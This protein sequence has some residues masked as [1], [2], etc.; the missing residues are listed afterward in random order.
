MHSTPNV[1]LYAPGFNEL[2]SS[3][4][5]DNVAQRLARTLDH[6]DQDAPISYE[7]RVA[8]SE[9]YAG[10]TA[11]AEVRELV[12]CQ[13]GQEPVLTHRL[14][15]LDYQPAL[16]DQQPEGNLFT[17]MLAVARVSAWMGWCFFSRALA[18]DSIR[19]KQKTAVFVGG[20][21]LLLL[22]GFFVVLVIQVVHDSVRRFGTPAY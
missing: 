6:L 19:S 7:V 2:A 20:F 17:R 15:N 12:R 16:A 18:V 3:G 1:I 5:I 10:G 22:T 4:A 8:E 9:P 21:F 13:K 11:F 14:Y